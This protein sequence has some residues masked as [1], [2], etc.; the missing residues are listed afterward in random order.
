V[1]VTPWALELNGL[2]TGRGS[3]KE[4]SLHFRRPIIQNADNKILQIPV[5]EIL[6][7]KI[8]IIFTIVS[9]YIL[10]FQNATVVSAL[11]RRP[12]QSF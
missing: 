2:G 12:L 10:T 3:S 8:P 4:R 6:K 7:I 11:V 5:A 9:H 1:C